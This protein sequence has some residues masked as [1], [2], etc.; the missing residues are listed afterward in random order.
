MSLSDVYNFLDE[1][2][3][4]R[5]LFCCWGCGKGGAIEHHHIISRQRMNKI[6]KPDLLVDPEN[7]IPLCHYCHH[8]IMHNGSWSDRIAL[9][10]W[11]VITDFIKKED[12]E[13]YELM[14][15]KINEH[16]KTQVSDSR[17]QRQEY[18]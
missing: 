18:E 8:N 6:G 14:L 1:L 16:V 15:I 2:W 9:K 3:H 4:D 7:I 13:G 10:C 12:P 11:D 17:T 5:D